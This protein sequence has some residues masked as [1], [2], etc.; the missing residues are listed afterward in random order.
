VFH[1]VD[2]IVNCA[3]DAT[4]CAKNCCEKPHASSDHVRT[5]TL[6]LLVFELIRFYKKKTSAASNLVGDMCSDTM[7]QPRFWECAQPAGEACNGD[8]WTQFGPVDYEN[9]MSYAMIDDN[10]QEEHCQ[11]GFSVQQTRR[12]HCYISD[13]LSSWIA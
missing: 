2:E 13:L 10:G 12:M 3:P 11:T 8:Q 6:V 7:S 9:T 5:E 1:G 4:T